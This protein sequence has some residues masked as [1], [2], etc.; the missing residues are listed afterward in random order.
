[1]RKHHFQQKQTVASKTVFSNTFEVGSQVKAKQSSGFQAEMEANKENFNPMTGRY[2]NASQAKVR[3]KI[4]VQREPL[5]DITNTY[6]CNNQFVSFGLNKA[7]VAQEVITHNQTHLCL[8]ISIGTRST[9]KK[10]S[11]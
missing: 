4:S 3:S 5:R 8:T 6:M 2:S 10:E 11:S 9:K 7:I 1:M